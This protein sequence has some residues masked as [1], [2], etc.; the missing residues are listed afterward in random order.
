[1]KECKRCGRCCMSLMFDIKG[2][3][4]NRLLKEYYKAQKAFETVLKYKYDDDIY[5]RLGTVHL[6]KKAY[7]KAEK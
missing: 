6:Y 2:L 4:N 7:D 3:G 5:S 1:M